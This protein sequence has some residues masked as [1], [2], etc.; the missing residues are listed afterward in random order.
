[1]SENSISARLGGYNKS[2]LS[3][4]MNVVKITFRVVVEIKLGTTASIITQN[5]LRFH[6]FH[7]I[8]TNYRKKIPDVMT[9]FVVVGS[10]RT[11]QTRMVTSEEVLGL[12]YIPNVS[13]SST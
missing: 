3:A 9:S 5:Q 7:K 6:A 13:I 4:L 11:A 1:M 10:F 8:N 2:T 12:V